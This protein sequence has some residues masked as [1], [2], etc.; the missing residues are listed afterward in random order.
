VGQRG[1]KSL[2]DAQGLQ[3]ADLLGHPVKQ[4]TLKQHGYLAEDFWF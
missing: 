4:W 2:R 3:L 1:F